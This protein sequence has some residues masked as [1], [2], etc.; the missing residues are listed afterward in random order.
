MSA[1]EAQQLIDTARRD[2]TT[3]QAFPDRILALDGLVQAISA[4][5][6]QAEASWQGLAWDK[7]E[8]ALPL[9]G[10]LYFELRSTSQAGGDVAEL[11]QLQ[12]WLVGRLLPTAHGGASASLRTWEAVAL[13]ATGERAKAIEQLEQLAQNSP[14]DLTLQQLL[15]ELLEAGSVAA[16]HRRAVD[17]W[18]RVVR[19]TPDASSLW[20][21]AKLGIARGLL[22]LGDRKRAAEMIGI[23]E[24]LHPELGG[25]TMKAEFQRLKGELGKL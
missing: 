16:E 25:P 3:Y 13:A 1:T 4:K 5:Y 15:A 7:Y 18:R 10:R 6:S 22:Q 21:R 9:A 14:R 8:L 12:R 24:T 11:A 17:H 19:L 23:L 20:F 2:E